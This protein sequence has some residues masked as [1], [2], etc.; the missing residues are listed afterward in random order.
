[1]LDSGKR[2]ILIIGPA[3]PYRGG[4]SL[5]ISYVSDSLK[6]IFEI[7]ILNYKLLYP[8]ILFPGTTQYDHSNVLIKRAENER[9]I[10]SINPLTWVKAALKIRK[11]K[12]DLVVIDWW[13]PFFSFCHFTISL[14]I[15]KRFKNKILFITENFISHEGHL[16]D[17]LLT[18]IGLKNASSFLVLSD[19]VEKDL[20]ASGYKKKI[21]RSELPVYDCYQPETKFQNNKKRFDYSDDDKVLLFFGYVRKYK[22]LD[23]LI[24]AIPEIIKVFPEIKLLIVGEFY[25]NPNFYYDKIKALGISNYIKII[26]KYVDNEEVG[27][28]YM[29]SDLNILPYRSATQSGILNVSYGFLKPVLVTDVG[30]LSESVING[31]TGIII[32]SN[33]S[34]AIVNGVKD[35]F[36]LKEEVDFSNN[37]KEYIKEN[38]F[39]KLPEIF[40]Q[41]L[42]DS[43]K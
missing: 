38:K 4:N 36:R 37:I 6:K 12:P 8:S 27:E 14:L 22:G 7:K 25:D 23:L 13:H 26:N 9:I 2:K 41:I 24:E 11:E 29:A 15:K 10:N 16:V 21:Y 31:K 30:G 20:I 33:S 35:F 39:D 3:Y 19:R 40:T 43:D 1:M 34:E 32:E 28:Y 17:K 18:R 5:F 42:E